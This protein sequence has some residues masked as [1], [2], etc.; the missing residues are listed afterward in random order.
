MSKRRVLLSFAFVQR[1]RREKITAAT[2]NDDFHLHPVLRDSFHAFII[3][4]IE[5]LSSYYSS[6]FKKTRVLFCAVF[7]DFH[8][9]TVRFVIMLPL[10]K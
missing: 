1:G 3:V 8:V 7:H 6:R 5:F 9:K 2:H 10:P 4:S